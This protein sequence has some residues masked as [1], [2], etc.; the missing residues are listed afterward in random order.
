MANEEK[1]REYL[2]RVTTDLHKTRERLRK[3]EDHQQ[4]P[5]A[6]VGMGCRFPGRVSSPAEFWD[7]LAA[8]RDGVGE[9]PANRG[10][11][12]G[13]LFDPDPDA[14]G[15]TYAREGGFLYGA[16]DF[17]AGFFGI[18]PRE[19]LG[20]D[21]QQRLLLETSWE[22][23]EDAGIDPGSLRGSRTGVFAG[24]DFGPGLVRAG[25]GGS[26][27]DGGHGMFFVAGGAASGVSGL[28]VGGV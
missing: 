24:R 15:K 6:I 12:A 7:L 25:P 21:P 8:G 13:E 23:L 9:F 27:G 5:V 14:V 17:D 10:W 2:K 4:E 18:S 1:L 19:A 26:G 22:A 3:I 20:M 11:D 16:G 28:A